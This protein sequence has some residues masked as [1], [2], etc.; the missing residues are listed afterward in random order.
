MRKVAAPQA[1]KA[2]SRR[3][4]EAERVA[5]SRTVMG[6]WGCNTPKTTLFQILKINPLKIHGNPVAHPIAVAGGG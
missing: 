4:G 6:L 3:G 1:F 5:P 2:A